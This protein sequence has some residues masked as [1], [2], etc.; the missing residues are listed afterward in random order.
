M[1]A[2]LHKPEL[3]NVIFVILS[4]MICFYLVP[5]RDLSLLRHILFKAHIFFLKEIYKYII[6][7]L[8]YVYYMSFM[9]SIVFSL[10][11]A[12]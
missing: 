5:S 3:E 1:K 12:N 7:M 9:G 2:F 10:Y 8:K 11:I 4:L 6:T